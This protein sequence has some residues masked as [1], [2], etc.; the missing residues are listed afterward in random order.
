MEKG[1]PPKFMGV[2][3][4]WTHR[5][6]LLGQASLDLLA[7][8]SGRSARQASPATGQEP[9]SWPWC[10]F[11]WGGGAALVR[12]FAERNA[13]RRAEIC[14]EGPQIR[15]EGPQI[16]FEGPL[17][18]ESPFWFPPYGFWNQASEPCG[19]NSLW[20]RP[21]C[22]SKATPS[23]MWSKENKKDTT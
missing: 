9:S 14:F 8:A 5:F 15:F 2:A 17:N 4:F 3:T 10:F 21:D 7:A 16:R 20:H 23:W 13:T 6:A 18:K 19:I 22:V 12:V 1:Q 11:F